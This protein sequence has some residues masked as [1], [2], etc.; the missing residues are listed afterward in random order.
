M[1]QRPVERGGSL[2]GTQYGTWQRGVAYSLPRRRATLTENDNRCRGHSC[3]LG[4]FLENR[5]APL[6][7]AAWFLSAGIVALLVAGLAYADKTRLHWYATGSDGPVATVAVAV[8][9]P[10]RVVGVIRRCRSSVSGVLSEGQ[11]SRA[12]YQ[13]DHLEITV[14]TSQDWPCPVLTDT[15]LKPPGGGRLSKPLGLVLCRGAV[16]QEEW[17]RRRCRRPR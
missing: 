5:Y 13:D 2:S 8:A 17:R 1:V 10:D 11:C 3:M 16:P 4:P 15:F 14:R 12:S 9:E 7:T 6:R